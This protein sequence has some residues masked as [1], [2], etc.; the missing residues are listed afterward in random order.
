[1]LVIMKNRNVHPLTQ[2]FFKVQTVGRLD[3]FQ[4]DSAKRRFQSRC[5]IDEPG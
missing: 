2:I 3:I 5:R 1:V 4:I